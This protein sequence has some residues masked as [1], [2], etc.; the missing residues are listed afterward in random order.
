M[1]VYNSLMQSQVPERVR[2]R[3]Y[4][5]M[6]LVWSLMRLASLGLGGALAD[7]LGVRIVY[8]LGGA[9]LFAAGA[10]GLVLLRGHDFTEPEPEL[11]D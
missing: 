1:V 2:G 10:L 8:Y 6:D 3:V 9:L 7:S 11:L 5:L 4:T